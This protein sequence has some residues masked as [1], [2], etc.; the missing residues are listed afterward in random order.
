MQQHGD[1]SE[2][3]Q[4]KVGKAP[5]GKM[6]K[7]HEDFLKMIIKLLDEKQIDTSNPDSMLN[8]D[9]YESMPQEWKGKTDLALF[10]MADQIRCIE[11]FFRSKQT[12]NEAPQLESMIE[13]LWQMKQRIEVKYDVF[14]F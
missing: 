1:L 12:P 2:E 5:G 6:T 3:D 11:D 10:N 9:V 4:K 14:K 13:E 7:E 8:T